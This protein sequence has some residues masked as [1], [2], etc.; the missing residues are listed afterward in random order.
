MVLFGSYSY[1]D[2]IAYGGV[3]RHVWF[4]LLMLVSD[5]G[6]L[7]V[8]AFLGKRASGCKPQAFSKSARLDNS[9]LASV[10]LRN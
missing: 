3:A 8:I 4:R 2:V 7:L 9:I 1:Y 5:R 6:L 10:I